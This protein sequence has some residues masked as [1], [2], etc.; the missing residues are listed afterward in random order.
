MHKVLS[1]KPTDKAEVLLCRVLVRPPVPSIVVRG[2][3]GDWR[4]RTS[5]ELAGI[6]QTINF[7]LNVF[8]LI[9]PL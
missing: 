5:Q 7:S 8:L 2:W 6:P 3:T 4:H 1:H 9:S